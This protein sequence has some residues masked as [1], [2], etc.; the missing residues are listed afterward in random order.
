MDPEYEYA[1]YNSYNSIKS[2]HEEVE[3]KHENERTAEFYDE[4]ISGLETAIGRARGGR[5]TIFPDSLSKKQL[6]KKLNEKIKEAKEYVNTSLQDE[7]YSTIKDELDTKLEQ[8]KKDIENK[9]YDEKTVEYYNNKKRRSTKL[10]NKSS[11]RKR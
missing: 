8:V 5:L 1:K 6:L 2:I 10:I 7:K 9:T 11:R 3:S 4:K